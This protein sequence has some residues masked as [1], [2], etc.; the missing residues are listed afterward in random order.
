MEIINHDLSIVFIKTSAKYLF[1]HF[2]ARYKD[3]WMDP[4]I[5]LPNT[6][7]TAGFRDQLPGKP[8]YAVYSN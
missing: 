3:K 1:G 7:I 5:N 8:T 4:W 6:D 2:L